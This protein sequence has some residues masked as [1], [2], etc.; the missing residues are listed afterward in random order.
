MPKRR[1]NSRAVIRRVT[2]IAARNRG[3][4]T[5]DDARAAGATRSMLRQWLAAG[6]CEPAGRKVYR[7][8]GS[9]V[10]WRQRLLAAVLAGGPGLVAARRSA[11]ALWRIPGFPE[12]PIE[13]TRPWLRRTRP[14]GP[15]VRESVALDCKD[16][17]S[18]D[19]IPVTTAARTLFD[20]A[21]RVPEKRVERAVDN[22]LAMRLV[23]VPELVD[24][25]R[26]I[27]RRGRHGTSAFRRVLEPRCA[28]Y[29]PPGSD[30]EAMLLELINEAALPAPVRQHWIYDEDGPIGRVDTAWPDS[31]VV[32]EADSRRHHMSLLDFESDRERDQRLAAA[33]WRVIR[34]SWRQLVFRRA[35]VASRLA[36]A[37]GCE[38]TSRARAARPRSRYTRGHP[39]PARTSRSRRDSGR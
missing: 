3:L 16:T 9:E 35:A 32:A 39:Q 15:S 30:F 33:Q 38:V 14:S 36:R 28:D 2:V 11:A 27:G 29:V 31:R 5:A 23:T 26:R 13:L 18:I 37:L 25:V 8:C 1:R 21:A 34:I 6:W 19:G 22:A 7:V 17:T 4:F 12:G 20:L 24:L 10:T